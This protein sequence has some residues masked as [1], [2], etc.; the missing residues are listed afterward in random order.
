MSRATGLTT[1]ALAFVM[2]GIGASVVFYVL[3]PI[4]I[5]NW[6]KEKMAFASE[7]FPSSPRQNFSG[8]VKPN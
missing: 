5:G 3:T 1:M 2:A 7:P 6:F 8:S 4:L